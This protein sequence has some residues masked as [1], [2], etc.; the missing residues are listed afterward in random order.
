MRIIQ[1]LLILLVLMVGLLFAARQ[2]GAGMGKGDVLAY[3]ACRDRFTICTPKLLDMRAM[4]ML[5]F[6]AQR[7]QYI[8]DVFWTENGDLYTIAG[9][10]WIPGSQGIYRW[11]NKIL[12]E[13]GNSISEI[14]LIR[15]KNNLLA[16]A[17]VINDTAQLRVWDGV[18]WIEP[19]ISVEIR[20]W[21]SWST[22]GRFIFT[23][24]DDTLYISDGV[25]MTN[26]GQGFQ[27]GLDW[28]VTGHLAFTSERDGNSEIYVWDGAALTNISQHPAYDDSPTW[29]SDGRLAFTS[30]RDGNREIYVWDGKTLINVSQT[31]EDNYRPTWSEDGQLAFI[32]GDGN[33]YI[34]GKAGLRFIK[35]AQYVPDNIYELQWLSQGRLFVV[36][37]PNNYLWDEAGIVTLFAYD[38]YTYGDSG[39]AFV[40][41]WY[42]TDGLS[43]LYVLDGK[44]VVGT[45]IVGESIR[46]EPDRRGGLLG[47]VCN[48]IPRICDL[49]YWKD[50]K[51]RRLTNTP[52]ISEHGVSF[53]P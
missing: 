9:T 36:S 28:G 52:G 49:Y 50:E 8:Q 24:R 7:E 15:N 34:W 46:F 30:E 23:S 39:V 45:G 22:D 4:V 18:R 5:G 53:R 31:P 20:I 14:R 33:V 3:V 10:K 48:G 32:T 11:G 29:S 35:F 40:S 21:P 6:H 43:E 37:D 44:N 26:L 17:M 13:E 38:I 19:V 1:N 12:T 47:Y 42:R 16:F 27:F 2:V 41:E 25:T 51:A